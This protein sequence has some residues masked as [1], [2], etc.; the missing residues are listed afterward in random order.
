MS[1]EKDII[2]NSRT[3]TQ[4]TEMSRTCMEKTVI[5]NKIVIKNNQAG[6]RPMKRLHLTWDNKRTLSPEM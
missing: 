2:K 6:K 5:N 3:F 1:G 4:K